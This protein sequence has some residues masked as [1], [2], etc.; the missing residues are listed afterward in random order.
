M[1]E[2]ETPH[3]LPFVMS[4]VSAQTNVLDQ[5]QIKYKYAHSHYS[6]ITMIFLKPITRL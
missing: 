2:L 5:K 6:K 1:E 3:I 4:Y